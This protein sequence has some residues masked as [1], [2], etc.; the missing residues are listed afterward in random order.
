MSVVTAASA[1]FAVVTAS[2]PISLVPTESSFRCD[3]EIVLLG[4]FAEVTEP[5]ASFAVKIAP[6]AIFAVLT[7]ESPI[8]T[9]SIAASAIFAVVTESA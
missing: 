7:A 8:L 3:C 4:I 6:S 1:I 9:V 2:P 5:S